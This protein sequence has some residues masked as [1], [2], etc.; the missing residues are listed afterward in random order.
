LEALLELDPGGRRPGTRG[1]GDRLTRQLREAIATGR[2]A[3]GARLPSSRALATDLGVARGVVVAAYEQLVAEGRVVAR[4]GSGTVVSSAPPAPVGTARREPTPIPGAPPRG[5]LRPGVPDLAMFPRAAWRRAYERAL[6]GLRDADLGYGDPTGA[7]ALRDGLADYLGRVR[8]ARVHADAVLVTTGAAQAFTL[9]AGALRAA[10]VTQVGVEEPGS[11]AIRAHLV[12]QRVR[13]VPLPVDADGLDVSALAATSLAAVL[14]TPAHQFPTG[15]VLSPARRAALLD[16]AHRRGGLVVE[17]D[18]DAEFRYDRDPVGCLQGL[19]PDRVALVGS[20]S[21][22]LAPALR[23]GWLCAPD[24]WYAQLALAKAHADLG[25][26]VVEQLAFAELLA[27]GGYDRHLR[28]IRRLHRARRDA[29]VDALRR[30]LPEAEVGGVA[31]G[32]HLVVSLGSTVDH[33]EVARRAYEIGL[34]P[35]ALDSRPGLVLGYAAHSAAELEKAVRRLAGLR[36]AV[37]GET[38]SRSRRTPGGP[39]G[40]TGRR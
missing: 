24:R 11:P 10:G 35:L 34:A 30:H 25:G 2:L 28:R 22:A 38:G 27:S 32:L 37:S 3:P 7:P 31:A 8:A 21:K 1:I 20:V 33:A 17:D 26:P 14:V 13:P 19:A 16:W 9:L 5:M 15:V 6:V 23:L 36:D 18:Y 4:R 39:L 40:R 12:A 29:L